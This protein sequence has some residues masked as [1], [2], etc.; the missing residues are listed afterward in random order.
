MGERLWLSFPSPLVPLPSFD[1]AQGRL[2]EGL[3]VRAF[4]WDFHAAGEF[5]Y[6][7]FM[8]PLL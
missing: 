1:F 8:L 5:F 3:G 7:F 6:V 4:S 2:G